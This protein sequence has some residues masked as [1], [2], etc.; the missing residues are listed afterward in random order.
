MP[1]SLSSP[2]AD[3]LW[4]RTHEK[5]K[6]SCSWTKIVEYLRTKFDQVLVLSQPGK[7]LDSPSFYVNTCSLGERLLVQNLSS[8]RGWWQAPYLGAL[9]NLMQSI[10]TKSELCISLGEILCQIREGKGRRKWDP[11]IW[12]WPDCSAGSGRM[13]TMSQADKTHKQC[14][15]DGKR[16]LA[17]FNR[18]FAE[19]KLSTEKRGGLQQQWMIS[20]DVVAQPRLLLRCSTENNQNIYLWLGSIWGSLVLLLSVH[21]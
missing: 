12:A 1:E 7:L 17:G 4:Y 10:S 3:G 18:R 8:P 6:I 9:L 2:G 15:T 14:R 11:R 20:E 19:Q 16:E 5:L 13:E 21:L